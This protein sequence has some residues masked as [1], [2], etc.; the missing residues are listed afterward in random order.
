MVIHDDWMRSGGPPM[1]ICCQGKPMI[2]WVV[3]NLSLA[4]D[5]ALVV[6]YNPNWMSM[7]NFMSRGWRF[8]AAGTTTKDGGSWFIGTL[9]YPESSFW[10]QLSILNPVCTC[11]AMLAHIS[12]LVQNSEVLWL[13]YIGFRKFEN[14]WHAMCCECSAC[15]AEPPILGILY[16]GFADRI[17]SLFVHLYAGQWWDHAPGRNN[18]QIEIPESG[19]SEMAG[20]CGLGP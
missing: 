17:N 18:W 20:S 4:A 6:I 15:Q 8:F 14:A 1:R 3:D 7:D 13:A 5:D 16:L 11:V 10:W 2:R 19:G 12:P 9:G